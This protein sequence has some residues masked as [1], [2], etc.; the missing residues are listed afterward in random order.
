MSSQNLLPTANLE[1]I[2]S[3]AV[4]GFPIEVGL[5]QDGTPFLSGRGLAKACGISN[6]TLVSWGEFTPQVGSKYRAGKLANLLTT[7]HYRGDRLFLRLP[8]KVKFGGKANVSAYPYQVCMAFLDYYAFA[9]N[10]EAARNSLRILS[11]QQLPNFICNAIAQQ[12]SASES[13]AKPPESDRPL[14]GKVPD[15]YFG[16]FQIASRGQLGTAQNGIPL[17]V[18]LTSPRN[19]EKAWSQYWYIHKLWEQHGKR[20][21][22]LRRSLDYSPQL[23]TDGYLK[24]Y[25]YPASALSDFKHWFYLNYI[26]DRFP[27]YRHRKAQQR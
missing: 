12:P 14:R 27:S 2:Q 10:K 1:V 21:P 22:Y 4:A 16:V 5:L 26:P 17:D 20:V 18:P 11:E 9:A 6:S 24:T 23:T 15:N 25:L 8:S 13:A 3:I 19:I 7:Y